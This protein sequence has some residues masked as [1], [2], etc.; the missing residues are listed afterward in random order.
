MDRSDRTVESLVDMYQHGEL[1]LPEIQRRYVWNRPQIAALIDSLYRGYPCGSILVWETDETPELQVNQ[2]TEAI[3]RALLLLDGQQRVLSLLK[4]FHGT[5]PAV[6]VRFNVAQEKFQLQSAATRHDPLWV[7]VTKVLQQGPVAILRDLGIETSDPRFSEYLERLTRLAQIKNYKFPVEIVRGRT[8]SEVTEIFIRVNS[9]GTRL[10]AGDLA[11]AQITSRWPGAMRLM[12]E[13]RAQLERIGYK[14]DLAF[15]ARC[16]TAVATGTSR[17][18]RVSSTPIE[19]FKEAW[20]TTKAGLGH[21][22]DLVR[23]NLGID[24][25]DW[26]PSVT[27]LVILTAYSAQ[28]D[29]RLSDG[30]K[31][32]L[33]RWFCLASIWG[34]YSGSIETALDEDL[35]S[36]RT[37]QPTEGLLHAI[38]QQVGR[39]TVEPDDLALKGI[40]N[41]LFLMSYVAAR[42]AGA[43]DWWHGTALTTTSAAGAHR[44]EIHHIFPR[45]LLKGRPTRQ[46]H[47]IANLAFLA[48]KPNRKIAA[49]PPA[50][51]L[52]TIEPQ[53][54]RAQFVPM[55]A[56]LWEL[57]RYD[58][59]L[60]ERRRLLA[61]AINKILAGG[62]PMAAGSGELSGPSARGA[63]LGP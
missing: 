59:F 30:E 23:A 18:E 10:G 31:T 39:F 8:Y 57:D 20:E 28:R 4:V 29:G 38:R 37:E 9:R 53:R 46:V 11:L 2:P 40:R 60:R 26:L 48:R 50:K 35:R 54:L 14:L 33:V 56:A 25:S 45:H 19:K 3:R 5:D 61:E 24:S 47:E 49:S 44:L 43:E 21:A 42:S 55:D 1:L 6:D 36:L 27:P 12:E 16:L 41:P 22:V 7:S 58:D 32:A 51:Y 63:H 15:L 62:A 52:P 34:R 17:F 13:Y